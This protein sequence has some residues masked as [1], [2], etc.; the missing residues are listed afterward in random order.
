[1]PKIIEGVKFIDG[2]EVAAKPAVTQAQT[3]AA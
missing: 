3:A 1:L 2:L